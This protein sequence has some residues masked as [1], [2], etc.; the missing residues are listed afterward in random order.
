[1]ISLCFYWV[2]VSKKKAR[3]NNNLLYKFSL[4]LSDSLYILS[5][6]LP[7]N[8][9]RRGKVENVCR[10]KKEAAAVLLEG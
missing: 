8:Q 2:M 6:S 5:L 4:I 9:L 3:H 10:S 7:E 1:M